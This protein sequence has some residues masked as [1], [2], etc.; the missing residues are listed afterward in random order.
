[1]WKSALNK[2]SLNPFIQPVCLSSCRHQCQLQRTRRGARWP[3]RPVLPVH[4]RR[5]SKSAPRTFSRGQRCWQVCINTHLFSFLRQGS[6]FFLFQSVRAAVQLQAPPG[7]LFCGNVSTVSVSGKHLSLGSVG[8]IFPVVSHLK[9]VPKWRLL[10]DSISGPL[11][12][13][14]EFTVVGASR[15]ET[16]KDGGKQ[17]MGVEIFALS[18]AVSL[19]LRDWGEHW[20]ALH[21]YSVLIPSAAGER[22]KNKKKDKSGQPGDG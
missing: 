17:M 19:S 3:V 2:A 16:M 9:H 20:L 12:D 10:S 7:G 11:W 1:M 15:F 22:Q 13:L 5:Q 18:D 6:V 8:T 14:T 21:I 4:P